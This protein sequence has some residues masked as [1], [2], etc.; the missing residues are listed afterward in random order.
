MQDRH[1]HHVPQ[2]LSDQPYALSLLW[3]L[4]YHRPPDRWRTRRRLLRFALL[5]LFCGLSKWSHR[6]IGECDRQHHHR[7]D[8][9]QNAPYFPRFHLE[10]PQRPPTHLQGD[11]TENHIVGIALERRKA[12][13]L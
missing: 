1:D 12:P 9:T 13:L 3:D 8:C 11:I 7:D 5:N 6:P 4:P 2:G 10:I